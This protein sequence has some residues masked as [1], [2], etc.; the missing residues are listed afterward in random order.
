VDASAQVISD[1]SIGAYSSV[2]MNVV[3]RG[4]VNAIRIGQ[5]SNVQDG[6]VVHVMHDTHPTTIG[7]DV[8]VGHGAVVHGCTISSRVLVG[9]GAIVLNGAVV[10]EDSIVAA[11]SLVPEGAVIA[12]RSLVMGTPAR[13]KRQLNDAE[14]ASILESAANYVR[15]KQDFV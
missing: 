9:M 10:G 13:F 3:I 12:P 1:V 2:S 14:V 15:Y 5:R 6:T 7:D 8:T 4:D 11:G